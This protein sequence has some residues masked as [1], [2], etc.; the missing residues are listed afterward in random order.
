MIA[1]DLDGLKLIND[2]LVHE[3]GDRAIRQVAQLLR[4]ALRA[5]RV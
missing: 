3:H 5:A 2:T 4:G 1:A